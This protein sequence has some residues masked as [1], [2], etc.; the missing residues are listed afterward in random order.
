MRNSNFRGEKENWNDIVMNSRKIK[1]PLAGADSCDRPS[2]SSLREKGAV[3]YLLP[4]YL[5]P[6]RSKENIRSMVHKQFGF[7]SL[8]VPL[9]LMPRSTEINIDAR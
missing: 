7:A 5:T 9:R 2:R 6:T 1:E 8:S 4:S 3:G